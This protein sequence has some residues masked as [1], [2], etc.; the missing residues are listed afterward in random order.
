MPITATDAVAGHHGIG[1][2]TCDDV[3]LASAGVDAEISLTR[4]P[5]FA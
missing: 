1:R 2:P 4:P 5:F 3:A